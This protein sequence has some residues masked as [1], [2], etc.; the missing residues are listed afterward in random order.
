MEFLL[1]LWTL[2]G[3]AVGLVAIVGIIWGITTSGRR[4]PEA[5]LDREFGIRTAS[6]ARRLGGALL[7]L[8]LMLITILIGWFIWF[9]IVAP[10]GQTPGKQL[11]AIHVVR[12]DGARAQ[13]GFMWG[14]EILVKALLL[15]IVDV[16]AARIVS[17]V[18][19]IWCIWDPDKQCGWDKI[20]HSYVAFAPRHQ[21]I[22]NDIQS[23]QEPASTTETAT[24]LEDP[25][26]K[27]RELQQL[28]TDG[29]I[30]AKEYEKRRQQYV[31]RL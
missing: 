12:E 20:M 19:S 14:R 7:D 23:T 18:A 10:R 26:I 27:L 9:C 4:F 21:T 3:F 6:P 13:A 30:S 15:P 2:A 24:N 8:F 16:F 1:V 31:N 11:V 17:T 25:A 22:S 28:R 5:H 29:I